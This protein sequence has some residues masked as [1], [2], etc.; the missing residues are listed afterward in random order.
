MYYGK[1][2]GS[3]KI[4][5]LGQ[6]SL[7]KTKFFLKKA[8]LRMKKTIRPFFLIFANKSNLKNKPVTVNK[9]VWQFFCKFQDLFF[10]VLRSW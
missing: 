8:I 1:S 2:A 4:I 5:F 3:L 10:S 7:L 9:E 6:K